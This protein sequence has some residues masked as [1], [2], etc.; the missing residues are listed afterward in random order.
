MCLIISN[1]VS[2]QPHERCSYRWMRSK[3]QRKNDV[4]DVA[5]FLAWVIIIIAT[6]IDSI[7][8]FDIFLTLQ[9]KHWI[10]RRSSHRHKLF[11]MS[12][13]ARLKIDMSD[14]CSAS[15][16][17]RRSIS[18]R[19]KDA[20]LNRTSSSSLQWNR[21]C[22]ATS[23]YAY[24][25]QKCL[26]IRCVHSHDEDRSFGMENEH[27]AINIQRIPMTRTSGPTVSVNWQFAV[28]CSTFSL[29]NTCENA[30]P[31]WSIRP[32]SPLKY[33]ILFSRFSVFTLVPSRSPFEVPIMIEHWCLPIRIFL[34]CTRQG[35]AS[36]SASISSYRILGQQ[37]FLGSPFLF[38]LFRRPRIMSANFLSTIPLNAALLCV[39][40]SWV[41]VLVI[42]M[43]N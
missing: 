40:S 26:F 43:K 37:P 15:I 42:D 20:A 24:R 30:M 29:V 31:L 39:S 32:M 17:I 38:T 2:L 21:W 25:K 5:G 27:R 14:H 8:S 35:N 22:S 10:W 7:I 6:K 16:D 41:L 13:F 34:D 11:Q 33:P 28:S 4:T 9:T 3:L 23:C 1:K 12:L 36:N 18:S 19:R